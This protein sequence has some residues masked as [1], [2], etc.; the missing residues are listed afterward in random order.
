[1]SHYNCTRRELLKTTGLGA[2]SMIAW[3]TTGL[4]RRSPALRPNIVFVLADDLGWK[5]VGYHGGS[6]R[7]PNID[8]L[9]AEGTRLEQF[10]VQ[11]VCSPTRS[12]LMT[13]RYPM[14]YGLQVGVVR[15]WANYGLALEER[16]LAQALKE[17]GYTT[18]ICGKWHLGHLSSEYL[19]TSRGFDHQYGHYN[20]ALDYFTHI[21]D[22]G[23]DWHRNDEPVRERGYTT[24][25]LADEAVRL[26]ER[27]DVSGPLFL[28]VPFNAVH[29]PFQAPQSDIDKHKHIEQ[30]RKRIFAAMVTSMD[31]AIGRIVTALDERG[32]RENTLIVFCSDNGGVGNVSDNGPLRGQKAQLYEGGIRVP[33]IVV[34]PG[35][36]K[37]GAVVNEPLHIV[38]MYPTLINLAGGTLEQSLPLDGKN[39]WPTIAQG[40]PTP[41]EE[42]LLNVTPAN[43][44]IRCGDWKLVWNASIGANNAGQPTERNVFELFNLAEDPSEKND[45]S[46]KRP[47]KLRELKRRLESY[48]SQAVKPNVPPN[49]KPG[50]F[51]VPKVWGHPD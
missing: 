34:W 11:P 2:V 41:H 17:A 24:D 36:L 1:M 23:L 44:A 13:G 22:G 4:A 49:K 12:S 26:I 30:K 51:K 50:D 32:I 9:A 45:L 40:K 10:Y 48:A 19:P 8:R 38:D 15:P 47:Q 35:V 28:Y 37:A 18:A 14:R 43:G 29:S 25:L 46:R 5:D 6:I 20:G 21:R 31:N 3:Q 16:T 7:T 33:A 39:A 42:I 27:H